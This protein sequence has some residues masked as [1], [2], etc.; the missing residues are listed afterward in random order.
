MTNNI[1]RSTNNKRI[2]KNTLML[3]IR[4]FIT[5]IV[6]LYTSRVIL[7][8]L[9][10]TDFGIYNLVGGIVILFSFVRSAMTSATQRFLNFEM[11]VG[12]A[13]SIK[14][15]FSTSMSAHIFITIIILVFAETVGLWFVKTQLNI[16][17]DRINAMLWVYQ[18]SVFT[19]C[20]N[21]L[22]VPYNAI[23]IA[24][25]K[26]SFYAYISIVESVLS[27]LSVYL[28]LVIP[29]D[30]LIT[31]AVTVFAVTLIVT[32]G[33]KI[34]S[35]R[36]FKSSVYNFE[37]DASLFGRLLSFS[38][39]SLFGSGANAGASQGINILVNLF[40]G[41]GVNAAM[42]IANQVQSAVLAFA[43][44]FQTAFNP[45]LVK[46]YA[47]KE[48]D[49]FVS[50]ILQTSKYSFF[51]IY[52]LTLP[53]ILCTNTILKIWLA[54]VPEYAVDFTQWILVFVTIEAIATPLWRSVQATGNIKNYQIMVAAITICT[55]PV[56]YVLLAMG[57]SP[58]WTV[59]ARVIIGVVI[60]LARIIYLNTLISFSIKEYML[61]V[62]WRCIM[63]IA[64]SLPLPLLVLPYSQNI[65]TDIL[66]LPFIALCVITSIC[67]TGL[68]KTERTI[69]IKKIKKS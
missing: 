68:T 27:L 55:I 40:F 21:I 65:Y 60:L 45:Q 29:A 26:M 35:N 44:S 1:D 64:V 4:T 22:R 63:V 39:W 37:W 15:V 33:Y 48:Y 58:V 41:V 69:I 42:G 66:M 36:N 54:E 25:E 28:L 31:Y 11:G 3:Y 19:A 12:D 14:K 43:N 53:M 6:T 50:L 46:S 17:S 52:M 24:Y 49:Y 13:A 67:I 51:L 7:S 20:I 38:G 2:A 34:Y 62:L 59:I 32:I 57:L 16:P 30:K 18:L 8:T 47:A 9:G 23:I 10:E 61:K 56:S 5:I